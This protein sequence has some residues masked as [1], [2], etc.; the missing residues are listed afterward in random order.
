MK[1]IIKY[2][3]KRMSTC[4]HPRCLRTYN[5]F[6]YIIKYVFKDMTTR[7]MV[8][9]LLVFGSSLLF[10][11]IKIFYSFFFFCLIDRV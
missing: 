9:I 8:C 4:N 10:K 6:L 3:F 1:K 2:V 5:L 11:T 7:V